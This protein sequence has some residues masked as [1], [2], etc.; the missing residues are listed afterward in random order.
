MT[1]LNEILSWS[2]TLPDWQRDA[3]RRL[4][5]QEDLMQQ[6]YDDLY[7]MLKAVHGIPDPQKRQSI[8]L[9]AEHLPAKTTEATIV[10]KAMRDLQHV[11]R[12]ASVK[13]LT[14]SPTG[15]TVIYGENSSGKSGYSRVLKRACRA[16]DQVEDVL[17]DATNPG[18]QSSIPETTFDIEIG[19]TSKSI[20]WR[21]GAPSPDD[22]STIAVFD[23]HCARAYLKEGEAAYLPYGMDIVVNLAE[24]VI[25]ELKRRLDKEIGGINVDVTPFDHLCGET[26]V[27]KLIS[28]LGPQTNITEINSLATLSKAEISRIIEFKAVLSEADPK[29]KAQECKLSAGRIKDIATRVDT[30][31]R[32]VKDETVTKL[33]DICNAVLTA[34]D[35]EKA[36]AL[37][38]QSG[39]KLLPGTGELVWK[40]LFEAARK[41]STEVAYHGH[42]FPYTDDGAVCPLCQQP[43]ADAGER[44]KRFGKYIQDDAAKVA[45]KK[46]QELNAA[47]T[48][49]ERAD[50]TIG[51]NDPLEEELRQ[52]DHI[53]VSTITDFEASI[54]ARHSWMLNAVTSH[55]WDNMPQLSENPRIAL[56]CLAARQLRAARTFKKA[57]DETKKRT[58]EAEY[59]DLVARQNLK[60]SLVPILA[61]VKRMKLKAN[62]DECNEE[63]KTKPITNKCKDL[64]KNV[65]TP[66]LK[67]AIDDE[68]QVL[69][70]GHI[71]TKLKE[72]T[73]KGRIHYSLLLDLPTSAKLEAI[74]SEGEQR[75]I[76]IGSFLAELQL[77]DYKGVIVFDDPV[78]SLDHHRRKRVAERI[79]REAAHRQ[80]IVFTHDTVFLGELRE[81][82]ER[83]QVASLVHHLEWAN[84]IP[85][86]VNE[87]LPWEHQGYNERLHMLKQ[88]QKRIEKGWQV[89]PIAEQREEMR[90]QYDNMRATIERAI[91]DIVFNDVIKPYRDYI[92]VGKLDKVG[93]LSKTQCEEIK[94]LYNHCGD[95]ITAH[96]PSSAKNSPVPTPT[97]LGNDIAALEAVI[98]TIK[99]A[100]KSTAGF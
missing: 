91:P 61:L 23:V 35:A 48:K 53:I 97:E 30:A 37:I 86:Y 41:F 92:K 17:T 4:F 94:R 25:P 52:L 78:S 19:A 18:E 58:L 44:L 87:G 89:Y 3:L 9:A 98:Q 81:Q 29:A 57:S 59:G 32:W 84:G 22:L 70:I 8:P 72:R 63:L 2:N 31:L 90:H 39:E 13:P 80:V 71:K 40:S 62:L 54:K 21:R 26:A 82:I 74:L 66:D 93:G 27:G 1:L 64:A 99:D 68:F 77:D 67:K 28:G 34:E 45:N 42:P 50:I 24:K 56:R 51:M 65:I 60:Q 11:N 33:K 7:A 36:A 69:D 75:A 73:E 5:Q 38:L 47:K 88:N 95:I 6:G 43:L 10:L 96:D 83:Q 14:F 76:A 79:V 16:R 100:R 12:I 49:I 46:R 85:G 20:K 15:I 55:C